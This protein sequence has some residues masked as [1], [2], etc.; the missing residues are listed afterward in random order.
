MNIFKLNSKPENEST[1]KWCC[2]RSEEYVQEKKAKI[3]KILGINSQDW[4]EVK[5]PI[6]KKNLDFFCHKNDSYFKTLEANFSNEIEES[7]A[8]TIGNKNVKKKILEKKEL[9]FVIKF[10]SMPEDFEEVTEGFKKTPEDFK[11]II[12]MNDGYHIFISQDLYLNAKRN[13]LKQSSLECQLAH[14]IAHILCRHSVERA[15]FI[16]IFEK[17]KETK[18][19]DKLKKL[20]IKTEISKTEFENA[21]KE[22]DLVAEIQAD[23]VGI[24]NKKK[25]ALDQY[26]RYIQKAKQKVYDPNRLPLIY[27]INYFKEISEHMEKDPI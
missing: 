1:Y 20:G 25:W 10:L 8:K 13:W 19:K 7:I 21:L 14:E 16:E 4:E 27:I 22:W 5:K 12:T 3:L 11:D 2:D 26:N 17:S 9:N 23:T 15:S 24:F 18:F 6:Y